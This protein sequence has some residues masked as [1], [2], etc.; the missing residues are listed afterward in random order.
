MSMHC[1]S[2]VALLLALALRDGFA[3]V[4]FR[5]LSAL[6]YATVTERAD[7]NRGPS[8]HVLALGNPPAGSWDFSVQVSL[9]PTMNLRAACSACFRW[10]FAPVL[11]PP[12]T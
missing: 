11:H 3:L 2:S 1:S 9:A 12:E 6:H 4:N 8:A 5:S 7:A 10:C